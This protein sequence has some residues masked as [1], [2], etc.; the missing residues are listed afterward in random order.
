MEK[1]NGKKND[2]DLVT[3]VQ[4]K[5]VIKEQRGSA[6]QRPMGGAIRVSPERTLAKL[7]YFQGSSAKRLRCTGGANLVHLMNSDNW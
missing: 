5:G 6:S 2:A 3:K 7:R 1:I 4:T